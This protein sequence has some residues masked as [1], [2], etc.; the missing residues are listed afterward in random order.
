MGG[1]IGCVVPGLQEE[2]RGGFPDYLLPYWSADYWSF[3]SPGW[4]R[5][6]WERSGQVEVLFADT[7]PNGW[8]QW[9]DWEKICLDEGY[10]ASESEI[11]MLECDAGRNLGFTSIVARRKPRD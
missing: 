1:L 4:W 2:L 11:R 6:H 8:K 3:H 7:I 9:L 5:G 10:P